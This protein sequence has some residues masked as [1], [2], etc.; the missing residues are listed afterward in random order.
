[1]TKRAVV[2]VVSLCLFFIYAPL[3]R[4]AGKVQVQ[5]LGHAAFKLTSVNGKVILVD[6]FL[7]KNPK[8][9]EKYRNLES[10]GKIDLI[11]ITHAHG[12]HVG[13]AIALA[14]KNGVPVYG[15]AGLNDTF[16]G[17]GLLPK[18][19]LPRFN[20][21][22]IV[23][24][25]GKG[26]SIT[27]T[28]AEHSSEYKHMS[29]DGKLEIHVGGEPAG[30]IVTFE[31]GFKV[32]H[33][34]DTGLFGDMKFIGSYYRPDLVLMPIGGHFVMSPKDAAYATKIYLRPKHVIPMHYGTFPPLK[35]TV[36]EFKAALGS[37]KNR[38]VDIQPGETRIY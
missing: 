22:G 34:G 12:D 13:D 2:A 36:A 28:R 38:V 37:A 10:L 5:W 21:G 4:A 19:Q 25:L 18:E 6:P 8:T 33:M 27:M 35:G 16:L 1:M 20:K 24:P 31:N 11:L 29:A 32:Y 3:S 7:T 9:P 15:P 14:K 17:L 30:F 23:N 26:I